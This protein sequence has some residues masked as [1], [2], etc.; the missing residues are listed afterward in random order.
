MLCRLEHLCH[1]TSMSEAQQ[2]H[3]QYSPQQGYGTSPRA[4][5]QATHASMEVLTTSQAPEP[6]GGSTDPYARPV[7]TPRVPSSPSAGTPPSAV[8]VRPEEMVIGGEQQVL[9]R[10]QL[11]DLLQRQLKKEQQPGAPPQ[12][13]LGPP[14]QKLPQQWPSP[15]QAM[16]LG[17]ALQ[18]NRIAMGGPGELGFRTPLP[19]GSMASRKLLLDT[20]ILCFI[21]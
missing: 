11:R 18:G 7:A 21:E 20:I 13:P 8:G 3:P 4:T 12:S 9:A 6:F 16:Q 5:P 15:Q 17:M 1:R 19:P 2:Q 14:Q 10:Q